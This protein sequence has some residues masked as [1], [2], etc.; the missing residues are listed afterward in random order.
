MAHFQQNEFVRILTTTLPEYFSGVRVLEVGSWSLHGSVREYF[1]QCDYIGADIAVG[2]GVDLI[3]QGQDIDKPTNTFDVVMSCECFEHNRFWL[4]TFI[5]MVRML[6][7][8]GL[9]ILTCAAPG[10]IEHGTSRRQAESSLTAKHGFPDYY[11]NLSRSH[12]R[13]RL[14]LDDHFECYG[15][16]VPH[17]Y[18]DLYFVGLK[19]IPHQLSGK[20]DRLWQ[21]LDA[22]R[23]ISLAP[24]A[25][26]WDRRKRLLLSTTSRVL[27]RMVGGRIYHSITFHMHRLVMSLA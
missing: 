14:S 19:R 24:G 1:S 2:P 4:E 27:D 17:Y 26:Q 6:K 25:S 13:K 15:F 9:F 23:Q 18:N 8:G 16:A 21:V 5:N 11:R 22:A 20:C 10:R 7:P 12:F 3:C